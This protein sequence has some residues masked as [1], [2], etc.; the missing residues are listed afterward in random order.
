[1]AALHNFRG[2]WPIR[3]S[4]LADL[5]AIVARLHVAVSKEIKSRLWAPGSRPA[6]ELPGFGDDFSRPT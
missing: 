2:R 5:A 6:S 1:L 4:A 3:D